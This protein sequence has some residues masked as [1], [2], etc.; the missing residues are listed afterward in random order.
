MFHKQRNFVFIAVL[1]AILIA[2]RTA[3][4]LDPA[5]QKWFEGTGIKATDQSCEL[6]CASAKSGMD[7][8][9]CPDQCDELCRP[10]KPCKNAEEF[11][12]L[13]LQNDAASKPEPQLRAKKWPESEIKMFLKVV[14]SISN[15]LWSPKVLAVFR[16]DRSKFQ[17]N[18]A[19]S[20]EH[21][22]CTTQHS[23]TNGAFRNHLF[24]N[25]LTSITKL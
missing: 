5:C 9:H 24:M 1:A 16:F 11:W 14:S 8:F 4:A 7:I 18:L 12:K 21:F 22:I 25:L 13:K 23:K 17:G 20:N 6:K 19:T 10:P 3:F 2:V 15:Q